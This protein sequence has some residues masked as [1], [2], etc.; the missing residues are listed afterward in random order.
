MQLSD[1]L[2]IITGASLGAII[3]YS[4]TSQRLFIGSLPVG[5]LSVNVIGS[6]IL[7][8]FMVIVQLYGLDNKYILFTAIGFC[9][10][11]TTM[12]AFAFETANMIE[13]KEFY[14]M[15]FNI[16]SNVGLSIIGIF[17]GRVLAS[18]ILSKPW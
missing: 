13:D 10:S 7:G 14:L 3:R 2:F 11:L 5:V 6:I 17:I 4:I 1:I 16:A 18:I 9:G 15:A 8:A 12:S